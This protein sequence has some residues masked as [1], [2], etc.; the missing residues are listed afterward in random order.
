[1]SEESGRLTEAQIRR[2]LM[3]MDAKAARRRAW[4]GAAVV[5]A[6]A[7]LVGTAVSRV[8]FTL[9]DIRGDGMIGA[10]KSGDVALCVRVEAPALTRPL[11]RGA[12]VLARYSD[13]GMKRQAVRRVIALEG[14]EVSVDEDGRVT[15]NGQALEE[16][17]ATYRSPN[18]W[19]GGEAAPGGALE[20]PFAED[21]AAIPA[22][23]VET[24]AQVDD[25]DYPMT[26]PAGSAFVLCDNRDNLLDSRSSRFGLVKTADLL[27]E[28]RAILWPVYRAGLLDGE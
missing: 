13:N 11:A 27:G 4:I 23:P 14:D 10:L 18:D 15:L 6:T 25:M 24:A 28:A 17:Y 20:N 8:L 16:P 12:L 3:R 19:A 22:A 1:M 2:E 5:L 21:G 26:I 9:A 7:L